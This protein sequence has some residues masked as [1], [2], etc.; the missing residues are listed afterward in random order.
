MTAL[1]EVVPPDGAVHDALLVKPFT[2]TELLGVIHRLLPP[3]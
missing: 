2:I 1:P 3:R